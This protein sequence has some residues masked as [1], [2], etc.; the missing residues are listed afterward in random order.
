M[1]GSAVPGWL[2]LGFWTAALVA[3][4]VLFRSLRA[5][6]EQAGQ[7]PLRDSLVIALKQSAIAVGSLVLTASAVWVFIRPEG[8]P[9]NLFLELQ[10]FLALS[11]LALGLASVSARAT[12]R[13]LERGLSRGGAMLAGRGAPL[14]AAAAYGYALVNSSASGLGGH[15]LAALALGACL[16]V[17]GLNRTEDLSP[18]LLERLRKNPPGSA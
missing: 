12:L 16:L 9:G 13:G 14:A 11:V 2:V 4:Q 5:E 15:A 7:R 1:S 8:A 6:A 18:A 10:L 17:L 3:Q